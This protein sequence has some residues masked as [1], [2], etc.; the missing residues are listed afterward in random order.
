MRYLLPLLFIFCPAASW[1]CSCINVHTTLEDA[2]CWADTSGGYVVE[3][4]IE[5]LLTD[6]PNGAEAR[7]VRRHFGP[8]PPTDA[9]G[10]MVVGSWHSCAWFLKEEHV[11]RR[12]LYFGRGS[13]RNGRYDADLFE[14]CGSSNIYLMRDNGREVKYSYTEPGAEGRNV[15]LRFRPMPL[16]MGCGNGPLASPL[17]DLQLSGSLSSGTIRLGWSHTEVEAPSL[18]A[19]KV[20]LPDG[21]EVAEM[22]LTGY[23]LGATIDLGHL[24][25]GLLL[26]LVDDG[27]HRRTFRMIKQ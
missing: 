5:R 13:V 21:R 24:P 12:F 11:G 9:N 20:Y 1:A 8:P 23:E 14:A 6:V 26:L 22:D 3:L 18:R 19:L 4:I 17:Q 27:V 16:I 15:G 25:S 10:R 2:L 7:V